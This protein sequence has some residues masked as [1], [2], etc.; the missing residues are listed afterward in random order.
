[1]VFLLVCLVFS[2]WCYTTKHWANVQISGWF[3]FLVY[4]F[5]GCNFCCLE[6]FLFPIYSIDVNGKYSAWQEPLKLSAQSQCNSSNNFLPKRYE[7]VI[8]HVRNGGF[9][10]IIS[11]MCLLTARF[12]A[13]NPIRLCTSLYSGSGTT[14]E[15]H[16]NI[17]LIHLW[18][19]FFFFF[20][21]FIFHDTLKP[22]FSP[23]CFFGSL[24]DLEA[25][26]WVWVRSICSFS[27]VAV[28]HF[29][30]WWYHCVWASGRWKSHCSLVNNLRL[31]S[32]VKSARELIPQAIQWC[33]K[34]A[35]MII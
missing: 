13:S 21:N 6:L 23:M 1:M 12:W 25:E 11:Q 18:E 14:D 7:T 20:C 31:Y 16:K 5:F 24:Q 33:P 8:Q 2:V 29:C 35:G 10:V 30:N 15:C 9:V 27:S 28:L 3:V 26:C 17:T 34:K 19:P 4:D 32:A 22:P